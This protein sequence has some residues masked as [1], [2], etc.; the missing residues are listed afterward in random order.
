MWMVC[1]SIGTWMPCDGMSVKS[2]ENFV[3]LM[4]PYYLMWVLELKAR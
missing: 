3:E 2:E 1:V 4:I